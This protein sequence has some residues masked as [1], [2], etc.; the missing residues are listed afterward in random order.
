MRPD[1]PNL[2]I[3]T[4]RADELTEAIELTVSNVAGDDLRRRVLD[5]LMLIA[6]GEVDARGM[7]VARQNDRV[8]GSFL[9]VPNVGASALVWLPRFRQQL[10][11]DDVDRLIARGLRWLRDRGTR[12]AQVVADPVEHSLQVPLWRAG[13][14]SVGPLV[15]LRRELADLPPMPQLTTK[16]TAEVDDAHLSSVIAETYVESLDFPELNG[17]RSMGDVLKGHRSAG[18]HR[19]ENWLVV[20][21]R[22]GHAVGVLLLAEL[23]PLGLWELSYL[24]VVPRCRRRGWGRQLLAHAL[25]HV[26]ERHG[27]QLE[28]AVD[29]RNVSALQLYARERF[30]RT[31]E[32]SVSLHFISDSAS[33]LPSR[34]DT[35][36]RR[37]R[38]IMRTCFPRPLMSALRDAARKFSRG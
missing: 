24:G 37:D 34:L 20:Y 14:R 21:D 38:P 27:E 16:S 22:D 29:A 1:A 17:T 18:H 13:F 5:V 26:Y 3:D 2:D 35:R 23:E 4:A 32:R 10:A 19:P 25:H 15:C 30:E 33:E 7:F 9:C 31:A 11:D 8:V 28:V 12:I 6:T 36:N